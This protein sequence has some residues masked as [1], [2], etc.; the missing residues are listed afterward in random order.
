MTVKKK[1]AALT[2]SASRKKTYDQCPRRYYYEYLQKLPRQEW[3]HFDLGTMVHGVLERFHSVYR[4]GKIEVNL[5][6]LMKE[7]FQ[8]QRVEMD[9]DHSLSQQVLLDA[10]DM[11]QSYLDSIGENGLDS[12][13]IALEQGFEIFL[14]D[15]Y[16]L[17]GVV[18]RLDVDSDGI[19][20]IRDYKTNKS[21]KYM[22]PFQLRA[23]G[24]YLLDQHPEVDKFRGSYIM[25][26]FGGMPISYDFNAADVD[27]ER[28]SLI[29]CAD[30][31][32]EEERWIAKPG[33][34]CDWCD[35]KGVCLNTW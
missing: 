12:T 23:Y 3:E 30:R 35:F 7:S 15:K 17:R 19:F 32:M 22:E 31:I 5:K 18:D 34:L 21:H 27:K 16:A 4:G 11:L 14:D 10:R 20:H 33:I 2:L 9:K 13:V 6:K 25:L 24:L 1:E 26:R 29:A 8:S 28:K